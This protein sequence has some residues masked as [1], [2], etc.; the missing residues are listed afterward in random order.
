[1]RALIG[2]LLD[3]KSG[4]AIT[5][6]MIVF[7]ITL[8]LRYVYELWWP[9]GIVLATILGLIGVISASRE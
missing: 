1:M 7:A 8:I 3:Q 9:F 4:V 2:W 5:L 6:G